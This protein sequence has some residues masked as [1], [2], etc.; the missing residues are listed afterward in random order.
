MVTGRTE[1]SDARI[2]SL[3]LGFGQENSDD[4]N[5]ANQLPARKVHPF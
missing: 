3:A 2:A 1:R 4:P 5:L